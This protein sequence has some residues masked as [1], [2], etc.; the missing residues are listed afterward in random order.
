MLNAYSRKQWKPVAL[1]KSAQMRTTELQMLRVLNCKQSSHRNN[2]STSKTKQE[3]THMPSLHKAEIRTVVQLNHF[4]NGYIL[5]TCII[6]RMGENFNVQ[7][8]VVLRC[9]VERRTVRNIF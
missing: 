3:Q 4:I 1:H 8:V 9:V 7:P 2:R 6:L 5:K